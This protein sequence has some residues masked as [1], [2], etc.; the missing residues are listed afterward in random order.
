M[1][2]GIDINSNEFHFSWGFSEGSVPATSVVLCCAQ[3]LLPESWMY[4]RLGVV[5][6]RFDFLFNFVPCSVLAPLDLVSCS[7]L[8][9]APFAAPAWVHA[10]PCAIA[11]SVDGG[12]FRCFLGAI[13]AHRLISPMPT[14]RIC[15]ASRRNRD[16]SD[17]SAKQEHMIP[18][19]CRS[20]GNM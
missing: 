3:R 2:S 5:S 9:P 17:R 10:R 13:N 20:V 7:I 6:P 8:F 12:S 4:I 16:V 18:V 15:R 11:S 14:L 19:P 1:G